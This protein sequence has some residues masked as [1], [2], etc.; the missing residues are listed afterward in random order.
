MGVPTAWDPSQTAPVSAFVSLTAA[1]F[2]STTA[3]V[4]TYASS[5][6]GYTIPMEVYT[7]ITQI[8]TGLLTTGFRY[9]I[10]PNSNNWVQ[11]PVQI[12]LYAPVGAPGVAFPNG[13]EVVSGGTSAGREIMIRSVWVAEGAASPRAVYNDI[14]MVDYLRDLW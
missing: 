11:C 6:M 9:G 13:F 4:F 2:G 7:N 14:N 8:T 5:A 12:P 1:A 3:P 10:S